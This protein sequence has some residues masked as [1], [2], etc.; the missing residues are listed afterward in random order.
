MKS[1]KGVV[2]KQRMV[3]NDCL[4]RVPNSAYKKRRVSG[5]TVTLALWDKKHIVN[6]IGSGEPLAS[7]VHLIA[8][9][10]L[11]TPT[12]TFFFALAGYR[13]RAGAGA[14]A[15]VIRISFGLLLF[16]DLKNL[17][18]PMSLVLWGPSVHPSISS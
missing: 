10:Y 16:V 9:V 5:A 3:D 14:G 2:N 4:R 8:T 11:G 6:G 17:N 7:K 13:P 12:V 1:R 18:S 15:V